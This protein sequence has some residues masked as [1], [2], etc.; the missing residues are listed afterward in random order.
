MAPLK[1]RHMLQCAVHVALGL[2]DGHLHTDRGQVR[3]GTQRAG[4][5]TVNA[6]AHADHKAFLAIRR[7]IVAQPTRDVFDDRLCLHGVKMRSPAL[8][9]TG[10]AS[11]FR[12]ADQK[13]MPTVSSR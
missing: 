12:P 4:H 8:V 7:A 10:G 2:V 3:S 1:L 6:S 9:F 11:K 5:R 13:K